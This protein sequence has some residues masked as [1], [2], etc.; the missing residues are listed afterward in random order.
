[1]TG[2]CAKR[3]MTGQA[4]RK[5][6]TKACLTNHCC[7]SQE[8]ALRLLG[9]HLKYKP[10]IEAFQEVWGRLQSRKR[11]REEHLDRS[12]RLGVRRRVSRLLQALKGT[13]RA[14][15]GV[16]S[17]AWSS[18][19]GRSIS[20]VSGPLATCQ[21]L[22]VLKKVPKTRVPKTCVPKT[23]VGLELGSCK[24]RFRLCSLGESCVAA[25]RLSRWVKVADAVAEYAAPRTCKQWIDSC[26]A[27]LG[28]L[29]KIKPHHIKPTSRT[30][31]PCCLASIRVV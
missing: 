11:L 28:I 22:G 18:T 10:W 21:A 17:K 25:A 29:S 30:H 6:W 12:G 14:M 26:K 3:G 15:K 2:S 31:E 9:L 23:R 1:M 5:K 20:H 4:Q 7:Y 16:D 13:C 8:P 19:V 24:Q 27:L